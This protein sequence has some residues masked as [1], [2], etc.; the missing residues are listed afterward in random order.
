MLDSQI[1]GA[2]KAGIIGFTKSLAREVG[3]RGYY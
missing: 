3:V 1:M 2:A